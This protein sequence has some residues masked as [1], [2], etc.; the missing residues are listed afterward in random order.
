MSFIA[1]RFDFVLPDN[2]TEINYMAVDVR[3]VP[4]KHIFLMD[5]SLLPNLVTKNN[6][7]MSMED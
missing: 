2:Q 6:R 3:E 4:K 1:K 5:I 7:E